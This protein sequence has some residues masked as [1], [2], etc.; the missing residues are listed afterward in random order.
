MERSLLRHLPN[1]L[2]MLRLLLAAGFFLALNQY[3]FPLT[4]ALWANVAIG[5]FVLA[6]ATDWLDGFLARRWHVESVFG[7][8][9]DPFCDKVL[10]LGGFIYLAGPRF[11]IPERAAEG[12]FFNMATGVYAWMVV[13][14]FARELLVTSVRGLLESMGHSGGAKLAGKLKMAL[15]AAVIPIVIFIAVNLDPHLPEW[16]WAA[17]LRDGLVYLTVLVTVWS[18]VPYVAGLRR[19][20]AAQ[21]AVEAASRDRSGDSPS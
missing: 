21:R 6:A 4:N 20:L 16:A 2:T 18:G 8:I 11:I 5:L 7:R 14:I 1:V 9:M 13:V 19:V 17:W 15:Q 10:V 12:A 3:R